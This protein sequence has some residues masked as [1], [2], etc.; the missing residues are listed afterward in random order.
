MK[1]FF[2]TMSWVVIKVLKGKHGVLSDHTE[3]YSAVARGFDR[4]RII[5]KGSASVFFRW[6]HDSN[7]PVPV[8]FQKPALRRD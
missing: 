2:V 8:N 4:K 7:G 3:G 6:Y 1:H 5:C